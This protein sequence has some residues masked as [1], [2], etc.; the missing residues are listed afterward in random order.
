MTSV[1]DIK[2]WMAA[3]NPK[4]YHDNDMTLAEFAK[5]VREEGFSPEALKLTSGK[6]LASFQFLFD[7]PTSQLEPTYFWLLDFM[8]DRSGFKEI[9]K[10]TDNF[11]SSPG[12]G[13][14][15]EIGMRATKMQEEGMKILGL[16]NQVIKT[17]VNLVYDLKE[18]EIRINNYKRAKADDKKEVES[19]LLALKQIWLDN[20]DMK[21]GNTGIK[22]MTF[23]QYSFA[24]LLDAFMMVNSKEDVDKLDLNDRVKRLLEQRIQEFSD[25]RDL[26]EKEINKRYEVEKSYLRTEV[27]S[28]KLYASWARPYLKAAEDLK[29]KGFE[30][31]D[32]SLVN[33]FNTAM[34]ELVIM[35]HK[36]VKVDGKQEAKDNG[37]PPEFL[38]RKRRK[39]YQMILVGFEF[40]GLP[41]RI[42]QRGDYGFG[43]RIRITMDAYALNEDEKKILEKKIKDDNQDFAFKLIED[44]STNPLNQLKEDLDRFLGDKEEKKKEEAKKK[45]DNP[46]SALWNI[47]KFSKANDKKGEID[48]KLLKADSYIE[49]YFRNLASNSA[50][51]TVFAIYDIY[52][53]AHGQASSPEPFDNFSDVNNGKMPSAK[54]S[55]FWS[56]VNDTFSGS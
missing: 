9:V 22:A 27:E 3:I 19:A 26:S 29:M 56:S 41:Q 51:G 11:M 28:L 36:E 24:T 1:K 39:Y 47:F 25:W 35:G 30:N 10:V 43:G 20:V 4:L 37:M 49:Q 40:R 2:K 15:G 34:F 17:I 38:E 50:K 8:K 6:S 33:T 32:P 13:H 42:S 44:A 21:K 52:K 48:V 23:S 54:K 46:F 53:K 5:K 7:A 45:E 16:M 14:F 31:N 55:E 18:F 12:S